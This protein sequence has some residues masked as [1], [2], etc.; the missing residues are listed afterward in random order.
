M[1]EQERLYLFDTTLRDGAQTRGLDFSLTEK[2]RIATMLDEL[3][4]DYI[5]GGYP[6]A[7]PVDS[8]FFSK[9]QKFTN[10]RFTAFGMTRRAGRSVGNDPGLRAVME[11]EAEAICLVGKAWDFHVEVALGISGDE[12]IECIASSMRAIQDNGRE[13]LFDAEHFFDGYKS[14]PAYALA[15]LE[16]AAEAGARW[17]VLCDTNGGTL[18]HEVERIVAAVTERIPGAQLGIHAHNDT[19]NAIANSLAAVRA[20][21]RQLQGTLNG[22][23]ER[24]GNAD[25]TA[26]IPTLLLKGE[27]SRD[28]KTGIT[29][30]ALSGMTSVS[31]RLNDIL[32]QAPS[33][34]A[35]YVGTS[36]FAHK[37]GIHVSAVRKDP[38]SYEHVRPESIGNRRDILVSGQAGRSNILLRLKNVGI[39]LDDDDSRLPR[40]LT[41]V[42]EREAQGYSYDGAEASFEILARR[43]LREVPEYFSVDSFRVLVERRP[44]TTGALL[45]FAEATVKVSVD[46]TRFLSVAEGDG[47]INA[48]DLALRKDLGK[49]T[50]FMNDLYLMDFK[51]RILTKGTEAITRVVIESRNDNGEHWFSVGVSENIVE[52][53]F[54]ALLDSIYYKLLHDGAPAPNP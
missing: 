38:R 17:L 11:A 13:A 30:E 32:N 35:P 42:K 16:A 28:F 19:G 37:G 22:L 47:P 7:N 34:S 41:A 6:G 54:Q 29:L 24:C 45:T 5:E 4:L 43:L 8:E 14:D 53:S 52:A 31:R 21:V 33:R 51:V 2:Q 3:G 10:A 49:Y 20:G 18:P 27:F 46:G 1:S 25:L 40:I 44:D 9:P 12:N 39:D 48:L 15:C 23:G 36:A 26:I 50:S